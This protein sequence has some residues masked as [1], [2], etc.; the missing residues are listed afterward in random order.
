MNILHVICNQISFHFTAYTEPIST[1]NH[2]DCSFDKT[3]GEGKVCKVNVDQLDPCIKS[4]RYNFHKG[5][6]CIFLKLNKVSL[7]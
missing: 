6:P 7:P 5:S 1:E 2:V 3:P 4:K